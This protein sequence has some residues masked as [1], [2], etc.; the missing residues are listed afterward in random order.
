VVI[1]RKQTTESALQI[2]QCYSFNKTKFTYKKNNGI[3][4]PNASGSLG[5][6]QNK[7]CY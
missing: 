7:S 1:T 5:K 4:T 6:D 2:Q 3:Q